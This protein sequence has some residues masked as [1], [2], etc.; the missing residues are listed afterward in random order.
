MTS[1][2]ERLNLHLMLYVRN[3]CQ[4]RRKNITR[5]LLVEVEGNKEGHRIK[6]IS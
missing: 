4:H 3:R 6:K 1:I 5:Y 2:V